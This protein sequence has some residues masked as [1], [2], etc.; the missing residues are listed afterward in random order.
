MTTTKTKETLKR[1]VVIL[2]VEGKS[3]KTALNL[4]EKFYTS[5]NIKVYTTGGDITSNFLITYNNCVKKLTEKIK[6][7]RD[8]KKLD[9]N[10]IYEI[11]H[12][13]DTDGAFI[14]DEFIEI[15][16][17]IKDFHY[18]LD[19]IK[20]N[21]K[22]KVIK[23]N[24]EKISKIKV[25][26]E[27]TK[28][29]RSIKYRLFFMSCNLDHVLFDE[30]N[31]KDEDKVPKAFEF[32]KKYQKDREGFFNFFNSKECKASGTYSETWSFIKKEKNSLHRYNNL[33]IFLEELEKD[34]QN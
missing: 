5:K 2:L 13:I 16:K 28:I 26:L 7:I 21:N 11:I 4:I 22:D 15:D 17:S 3:D 33:W 8:D 19:F 23:R 32:R 20:A 25:L 1:K 24:N 9:R 12:L 27:T 31:L 30:M 10:D 6:E 34:N 29:D 18:T 14:S